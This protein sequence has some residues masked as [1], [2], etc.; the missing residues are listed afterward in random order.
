MKENYN[1]NIY[2]SVGLEIYA[3]ERGFSPR[4]SLFADIK[5]GG[6]LPPLLHTSSRHVLN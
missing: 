1:N 6:A 2:K 4:N 3:I 5:N